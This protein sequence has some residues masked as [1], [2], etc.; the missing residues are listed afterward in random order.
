MRRRGAGPPRAGTV[1]LQV[2]GDADHAFLANLTVPKGTFP[3]VYPLALRA[4]CLIVDAA[5]VKRQLEG[6]NHARRRPMTRPSP[7][8]G[9]AVDV[10]VLANDTDPDGDD[11]YRMVLALAGAPARGRAEVQ[12]E[13]T[14]RYRPEQGFTGEERFTYQ[15]CETLRARQG[16]A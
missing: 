10:L 1:F 3:G 13:G 15:L 14:I 7:A 12:P 9:H 8:R 4:T 11:G 2:A 6:A 5:Q 16:L